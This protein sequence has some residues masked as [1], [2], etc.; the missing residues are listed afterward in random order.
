M[1]IYIH[2]RTQCQILSPETRFG[3]QTGLMFPQHAPVPPANRGAWEHQKQAMRYSWGVFQKR[4][5]CISHEIYRPALPESTV[6]VPLAKPWTLG[7]YTSSKQGL[8]LIY[9][10]L[11][12]SFFIF[13]THNTTQHSK[14][15]KT[16]QQTHAQHLKVQSKGRERGKDNKNTKVTPLYNHVY[17][18]K[19][20]AKRQWSKA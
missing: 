2:Y 6:N 20:T 9:F 1:S 8:G 4:C 16:K 14:Y 15:N 5:A 7:W 11:L 3:D 19:N 17:Q 10:Y 12:S 18:T 13:F